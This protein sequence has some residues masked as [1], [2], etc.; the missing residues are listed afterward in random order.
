MLTAARPQ[1]GAATQQRGLWQTSLWIAIGGALVSLFAPMALALKFEP[2]LAVLGAPFVVAAFTAKWP[3]VFAVVVGLVCV[4]QFLGGFPT[5]ADTLQHP[6]SIR[7]FLPLLLFGLSAIIGAI[8]SV[9]AFRGTTQDQAAR[10]ILAGCAVVYAVGAMV[11]GVAAARLPDASLQPGDTAIVARDTKF[12][13]ESITLD[14]AS[15]AL[16]VTNDDATRHTFTVDRLGIDEELPAKR[17]TRLM[18]DGE[19]GTYRYYC[20][21]HPDMTGEL[22]LR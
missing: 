7:D 14:T 1:A 17:A 5:L 13:E 3:R 15:S 9:P 22:I 10:F 12:S 18:I 16:Y 6:E 11:S 8:A 21:P 4:V 19:P 2:F 20:R